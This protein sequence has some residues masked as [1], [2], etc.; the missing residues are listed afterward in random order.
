M[1]LHYSGA[2]DGHS[3]TVPLLFFTHFHVEQHTKVRVAAVEICS[4]EWV[5]L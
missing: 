3:M 1:E 2:S 5:V 4:S